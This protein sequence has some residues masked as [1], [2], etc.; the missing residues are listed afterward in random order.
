MNNFTVP[1]GCVP[2]MH[3]MIGVIACLPVGREITP[4]KV[5]QELNSF[6]LIQTN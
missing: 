2:R 4:Y 6:V 1:V 5:I 3:R